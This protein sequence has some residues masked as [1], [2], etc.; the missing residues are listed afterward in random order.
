MKINEHPSSTVQNAFWLNLRFSSSDFKR[1]Y[2]ERLENTR[3]YKKIVSNQQVENKDGH[4][5]T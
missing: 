5:E 3:I 1:T 2:W 4:M